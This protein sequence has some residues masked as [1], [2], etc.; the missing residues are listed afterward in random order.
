[1]IVGLR[2]LFS[3]ETTAEQATFEKHRKVIQ[4]IELGGPEPQGSM[5]QSG[6]VQCRQLGSD[7][8]EEVPGVFSRKFVF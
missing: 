4:V 3:A 6:T 2:N 5:P 1:M 7:L 8:A